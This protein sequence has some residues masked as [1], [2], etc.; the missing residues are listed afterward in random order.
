M[1]SDGREM[2]IRCIVRNLYSFYFV[3][4]CNL[5]NKLNKNTNKKK[6]Q[7]LQYKVSFVTGYAK[8][9]FTIDLPFFE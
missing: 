5:P 3:V 4:N 2:V 8:N 1:S 6:V 9:F 7:I